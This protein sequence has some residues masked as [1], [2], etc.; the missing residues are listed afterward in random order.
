VPPGATAHEDPGQ[1]S[2]VIVHAP[3]AATHW[4]ALHTSCG[5]PPSTGLGTHGAPLQ[6]SAPDEHAP[7]AATHCAG[8]QRGTP[9]L[10]WWQVSW[11]SQLP[12]QQ[13]HEALQDI[14]DSLHTSPSG[15]QPI[16]FLHTPT[17]AGA[18]MTHVTGLPDPP[19]KPADPQQSL[20]CRQRS[21][22][23]WH[24]LAGWQMSTPVGPYGAH[25]RLQHPPPQDGR[26]PSTYT[27]PPSA[28]LPPQRTPSTIPQLA[29]PP[30]GD[31]AQV[32]SAWPAAV[33]HC[34]LQQSAAVAHESP[35][36]PQ[37]DDAWQ[38]PLLAQ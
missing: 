19:G 27:T 23:T 24:P 5:V 20:S 4:V 17:V 22:T 31:V 1:Q 37:N 26:P 6:Q 34:P 8:E 2:A 32:P 29:G 16:G 7:A 15:L 13:S 3:H 28:P 25:A 9:R 33:V 36:C 35:P 10:S 12:A 11:F 21:P 14:V 38:V 18:V 30:G